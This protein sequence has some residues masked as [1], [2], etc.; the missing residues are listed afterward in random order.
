MKKILIISTYYKPIQCVA[1]N[2]INAFAKYLKEFGYDVT[3]LTCSNIGKDEDVVE[4]NIRVIRLCNDG[5]GIFSFFNTNKVET[6]IIHYA[7]CLYNIV[8]A[9][10]IIDAMPKWTTKALDLAVR[11]LSEERFDYV[12]TSALPVGPHIIGMRLKQKYPEVKWIADMR[13]AI[14]EPRNSTF[15]YKKRILNLENKILNECDYLLAVSKPQ[16]ELFKNHYKGENAGKFYQIRNGFD[17]TF[18]PERHKSKKA[19]FSIIYAGSFYGAIKPKNFFLA[20]LHV[21]AR[22][23]MKINLRIIGNAAPIEIPLGLKNIVTE[24]AAIPYEDICNEMKNADALLMITPSCL[25][26]GIYTGKLFDYLGSGTPIIALAPPNDVAGKLIRKAN[27]GYVAA[28]EDIAGIENIIERVYNDWVAGKK[29]TPNI[30]IIKAHTR[31]EQV[32][33]LVHI[34]QGEYS[35][36]REECINI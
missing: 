21:L 15:I 35:A 4:D 10:F 3:V 36:E 18:E 30:A 24:E 6:F 29:D 12:L 19:L 5:K 28:N 16:A 31:K 27:A 11:L 17:F 2:R 20:L 22:K 1:A 32:R 25:E 7:K 8:I 14:S 9:N 13:D 23:D 33:R 26:K 34:L